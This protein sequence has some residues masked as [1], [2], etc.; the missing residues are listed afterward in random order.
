MK[1]YVGVINVAYV[2]KNARLAKLGSSYAYCAMPYFPRLL[3]RFCG[4]LDGGYCYAG[5]VKKLDGFGHAYF[6][7]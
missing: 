1:T 6:S 3:M 7:R 4:V 5:E 2:V